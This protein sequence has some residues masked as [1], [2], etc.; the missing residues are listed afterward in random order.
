MITHG[1]VTRGSKARLLRDNVVVHD[2]KLGSLRRFKDDVREVKEGF[3]CGLSF[4]G[5]SDIKQGDVSSPTF[6]RRSGPRSG[7]GRTGHLGPGDARSPAASIAANPRVMQ[8]FD[9]A[10][11]VVGVGWVDLLIPESRSLKEKRKVVR[12]TVDRL[13]ARFN[14]AVAEVGDQISGAAPASASRWSRTTPAS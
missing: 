5:F 9:E 14:V 6:S 10:G 13:R 1:T 8:D 3:E 12:S 11:M 7:D 4:D 2:G